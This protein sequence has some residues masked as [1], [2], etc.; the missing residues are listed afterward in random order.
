M[1]MDSSISETGNGALAQEMAN[2]LAGLMTVNLDLNPDKTFKMSMMMVPMEG[3]WAVKGQ[4]IEM[5][6]TKVLGVDKASLKRPRAP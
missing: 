1:T 2:G 4:N 5:T 3:T 6:A